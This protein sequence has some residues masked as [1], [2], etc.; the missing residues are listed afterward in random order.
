MFI[1]RTLHK[2]TEQDDYEN[3]CLPD[4][5]TSY[6]VPV[7]FQGETVADVISKASDFIG[8]GKEGIELDACD[9]KGRVDFA[10]TE[11]V[12][13]TTLTDMETA[14]WKAGELKAYYAVYTGF[15]ESLELVQ[16]TQ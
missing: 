3:G 10:V 1:I 8:C 2:F 13:G 7:S 4:T 11:T 6:E 14:Q 16:L 5:G 15:V 12:Y 9:E